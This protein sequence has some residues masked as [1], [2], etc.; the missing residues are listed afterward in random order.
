MSTY[1]IPKINR[2]TTRCQYLV[3]KPDNKVIALQ[4]MRQQARM[5]HRLLLPPRKPKG[6]PVMV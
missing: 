6:M 4:S 1:P 5:T 2:V 3:A